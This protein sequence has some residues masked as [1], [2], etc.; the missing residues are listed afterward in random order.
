[1]TVRE[2]INV[3]LAGFVPSENMIIRDY[4]LTFKV[5]IAAPIMRSMKPSNNM[6]KAI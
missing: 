1:M 2:G 3:F 5:L 4:E 6:M